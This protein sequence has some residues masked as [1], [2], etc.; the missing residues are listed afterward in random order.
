MILSSGNLLLI[1]SDVKLAEQLANYY[2]RNWE[3]LRDFEATREDSFFTTESQLRILGQEMESER[4]RE[5]FRFY[6]KL[7]SYPNE[8]MGVAGLN[9]VIWGAFCSSF[10]GYRL[11]FRHINK[12]YMTSVVSMLTEYAFKT[13]HLH[14]IEANVMPQNIPSLRV[15]EKCGYE[16]EGLAKH[17][18]KINGAWEDHIHMV[19]INYDMHKKDA[20]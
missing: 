8:I 13:L 4:R 5:S 19:K 3:F 1:P 10:L 11:D 20:L 7:S 14:R 6:I 2:R 12:G 9:N 15:L 18:L 16:S 17:Y